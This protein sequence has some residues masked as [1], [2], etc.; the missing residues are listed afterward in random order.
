MK[1]FPVDVLPSHVHLSALD[2]V[3][4]FGS[5]QSMTIA[6][7]H[8]QPGQVVYAETVAVFGTTDAYL[9]LSILGPPWK[10]TS[11]EL[12]PTEAQ[13][14][15]CELHEAKEGDKG[16]GASV[17]LVGPAGEVQLTH[18]AIIPKTSLLMSMIDAKQL[19]VRNGDTVSVRITNTFKPLEQVLVRVHPAFQLRLQ[20][21]ADLARDLWITGADTAHV[22]Q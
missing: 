16:V 19:H 20:M 7:N 3:Q 15:G 17:R 11:V 6:R 4:L 1:R 8:V 10:E 5:E 2:Q 14:I 13:L 12:T 18:G 9:R 21:H 22:I